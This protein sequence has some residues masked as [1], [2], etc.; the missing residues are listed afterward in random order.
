MF[1]I[2][3]K[4]AGKRTETAGGDYAIIAET[5]EK[6]KQFGYTPLIEKVVKFDEQIYQQSVDELDMAAVIRAVNGMK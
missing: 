2:T 5:P 4:R 3:I 1:T 6:G